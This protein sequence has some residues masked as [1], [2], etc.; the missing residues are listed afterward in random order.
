MRYQVEVLIECSEYVEVEAIS[1]LEAED[2]ATDLM[3]AK[4]PHADTVIPTNSGEL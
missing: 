3:N 1:T 4:Y 2:K